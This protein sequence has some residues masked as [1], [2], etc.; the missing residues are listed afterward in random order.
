MKVTE[1]SWKH[2]ALM[3]IGVIAVLGAL[4]EL[5]AWNEEREARVM[6]AHIQKQMI[7]RE[8]VFDEGREMQAKQVAVMAEKMEAEQT[9]FHDDFEKS[10]NEAHRIM[11]ALDKRYQP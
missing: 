4:W 5:K 2:I 6:I 1:L 7:A 10:W 8:K 11:E 9:R 3:G